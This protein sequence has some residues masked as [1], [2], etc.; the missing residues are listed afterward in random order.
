[1]KT[2][3]QPDTIYH[4]YNHANGADNLFREE[5]NYHYFLKKYFEYIQPI[6]KTYAYCLMPNHFHFM[7]RVR[8]RSDLL[9]FFKGRKP[10]QGFETLDEVELSYLI[11]RQFSNLFNGYTQAINK[12]YNRRGSLFMS[13]FRRKEIN[14]EAYFSAL[15]KYIHVNPIKHGFT[16]NLMEWTHSSVHHYLS[17][18]DSQVDKAEVIDWFGGIEAMKANHLNSSFDVTSNQFEFS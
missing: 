5:K 11:S 3:L 16:K 8:E 14:D 6:A 4:I 1:M 18:G 10:H 15:V 17:E 9:N 2:L 13:N 12:M 7:V